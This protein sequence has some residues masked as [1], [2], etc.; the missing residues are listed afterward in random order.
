LGGAINAGLRRLK[1]E[2]VSFVALFDQDSTISGNMLAK[3]RDSYSKISE[4]D[5]T[6]IA[7]GPRF[8][9]SRQKSNSYY[10]YYSVVNR[11]IVP[12]SATRP[13][14]ACR[15]VDYLIT[16]GM[17]I[18][19]ELINEHL[20]FDE[21]FFVDHTDTEWCFRAR[22]LGYSIYVDYGTEM[23]H[24]L[25][26]ASPKPFWGM[27]LLAYNARRRYFFYRNTTWLVFSKSTNFQWKKRFAFGLFIKFIPNIIIDNRKCASC[28]SMIRGAIDGV[29]M[30]L[31]TRISSKGNI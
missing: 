19:F 4:V 26:D 22:K 25:S 1:S 5:K 3:L 8:F 29:F 13:T 23:G 10:E 24:A 7:V 18:N 17:L 15:K 20:Y 6:C 21:W 28:L 16:S 9:D 27:S 12:C 31:K 14:D 2:H 30:V 11:A